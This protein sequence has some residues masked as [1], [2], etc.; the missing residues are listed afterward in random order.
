MKGN[1]KE[2]ISP[3]A[4]DLELIKKATIKPK[5]SASTE[6]DSS[7]KKIQDFEIAYERYNKKNRFFDT[8]EKDI[9][10][11]KRENPIFVEAKKTPQK[12]EKEGKSQLEEKET[13]EEKVSRY[14][15]KILE[16]INFIKEQR[17]K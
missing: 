2:E 14:Q 8:D 1:N 13:L 16:T 4:E 6:I 10:R 17:D 5:Q 12:I 15:N 9:G 11:E 3:F 7:E